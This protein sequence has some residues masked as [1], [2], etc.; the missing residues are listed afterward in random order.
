MFTMSVSLAEGSRPSL[1]REKKVV[2]VDGDR[3][4]WLLRW[5]KQ[6]TAVCAAEEGDVSLTCPYSGFA[7]GQQGDLSLVRLS[8]GAKSELLK[9]G[10]FFIRDEVPG[11]GPAVLQRWPPD[12]DKDLDAGEN[13]AEIIH[14]VTGRG[15]TDV[16]KFADYDHDGRPTEFLLQVGTLLC[17]KHQMVLVGISKQHPHLH[18][19][20]AV[21]KPD[22]PL[23]P[24][25]W[26]WESLLR[27]R[28]TVRTIAWSCGDHGS[29]NEWTN[30]ISAENGAIHD[31]RT[32]RKCSQS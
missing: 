26:Q 9:L 5:D 21:E 7:Y 2:I 3:E 14:T 31:I 25:A 28:G 19:F 4:T 11:D 13:D 18:V 22:A 20:A 16:M 6:R 23:V 29:E 17:G 32:N 24:G 10:Q 30:S 12:F 15:Q 27:G 1:L 8:P